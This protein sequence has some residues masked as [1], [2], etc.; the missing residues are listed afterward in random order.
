MTYTDPDGDDWE[1]ETLDTMQIGYALTAINV[2]TIAISNI[3]AMVD[4]TP[5]AGSSFSKSNFMEF[6]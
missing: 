6:M 1:Q 3:Y 2:Q 5:N 4:Y